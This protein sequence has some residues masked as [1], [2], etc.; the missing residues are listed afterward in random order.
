MRNALALAAVTAGLVAPA[1]RA[2]EPGLPP[3]LAHRITVDA[4]GPLALCEVTR[5]LAGTRGDG[6]GAEAILDLALPDHGVL[7]SIEVRDGERWRDVDQGART[8]ESARAADLYQSESAARGATAA[9][10]PYDD[11]AA[12]RVR[13]ARGARGGRAPFAV[14]YRFTAPPVFSGGRYRLRFPPAPESL[15]P[16]ADVAVATRD[17]SDVDIAGARAAVAAGHAAGRASTRA[18]WE[19]SWAP[20]EPG[21]APEA[22]ALEARVAMSAISPAETAVAYAVR[23]RAGRPA[24]PPA[25]VL[26]LVDRSRS[27]GLPGLSAERDLGR[28]LL[29]SLP[30]SLRFDALFFDRGTKRL[31]PMSR[32]ATREALDAFEAEMVPSRLENGTD[33]PAALREAGALLRREASA[34]GPRALL[35]VVTDG[36]IP[37]AHD[38]GALDRALG[39]VPGI[40]LGVAVF[41]VRPTDDEAVG[42]AARQALRAFA[43]ARGGVVREVGAG[44]IDEAVRE[45]LAAVDRG[46]DLTAV[47][48]VAGSHGRQLA[49]AVA[50]GAAATGVVTLAGRPPEKLEIE[51]TAGGRRIAVSPGHTTVSK[52]WVRAL[53]PAAAAAPRV[54]VAPALVALVEPVP[55]AA[56]AAE[57]VVKGSMDRM[58]M[59][60]VLSL[61]Y[62]PRARACYLDR[63]GATPAERDLAGRVRLAIDVARGE[64]ER[65]NIESSTLNH[66][67]IERCLREG[68]FAIEVPRAV[69]SDAPVTAI[70]N[71][72][73]RPRTPEKRPGAAPG[74]LGD[75]IDVLIEEAQREAEGP[76]SAAVEPPSTPPSFPTR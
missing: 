3:S 15:P 33:L 65:A 58:V 12:F 75:Q 44:D 11:S 14:R 39:R 52:P 42:P 25:S 63:R 24:A 60:N 20:R 48:L 62:M 56:A 43:G 30:P 22:P 50:A 18:G 64:V 27:V 38:G 73:F 28:R 1:A 68:A 41:A 53:A 17:A 51:A 57:P 66:A 4:R 23:G 70:L 5:E 45:G 32:P 9:T 34:F 29:E 36:A 35:V 7:V 71:L 59:R 61:A 21:A 19:I 10:E 2:R 67:D 72:V 49:E 8:V 31:F 76:P 16:P 40:D 37:D 6:G 13:V 69:R 47:R 26:L 55:R 46:G 74:G 54:L